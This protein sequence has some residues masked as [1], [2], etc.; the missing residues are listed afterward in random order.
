MVRLRAAH[1]RL[2]QD[3]YGLRNFLGTVMRHFLAVHALPRRVITR[4]LRRALVAPPRRAH[5]APP[6]GPA[7][8]APAV[9]ITAVA[10]PAQEEYLPALGAMADDKPERVHVPGEATT[11]NWTSGSGRATNSCRTHVPWTT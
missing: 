1:R 10:A 3:S 9:A 7:T 6:R 2:G 8:R 4:A 11:K 5:R